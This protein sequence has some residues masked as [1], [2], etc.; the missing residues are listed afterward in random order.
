MSNTCTSTVRQNASSKMVP[1]SGPDRLSDLPDDLLIKILSFLNVREVAQTCILSKRWRNLWASVPCLNFDLHE[2]SSQSRFINFVSSFLLS[3]DETSSLD[4][5]QLNCYGRSTYFD[6]GIPEAV[7]IWIKQAVQHKLKK[8]ELAFS[9][10]KFLTLPNSLYLCD[11]LEQLYFYLENCDV[12]L[13]PESVYL[14]KLKRLYLCFVNITGDEMDKILNGCPMLESLFVNI[15]I[16]EIWST[17]LLEEALQ[18]LLVFHKL[19]RLDLVGNTES[20][21]WVSQIRNEVGCH[22]GE[23]ESQN[24]REK[25]EWYY[26]KCLKEVQIL[27]FDEGRYDNVPQLV[28]R[29]KQSTRGLKEVR[30]VV[31]YY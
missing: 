15:E 3:F 17:D 28:E 20:M 7:G 31:S 16:L 19:K 18:N 30:I 4:L 11:S 25:I 2:F 27:C 22:C 23:N 21:A 24:S 10:C 29:V 8:L 26:C 13:I 9:Y 6:N 12:K 1:Y 14:P 5:F